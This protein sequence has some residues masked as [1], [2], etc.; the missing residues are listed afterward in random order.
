VRVDSLFPATV[1]AYGSHSS[2][3]Q[4]NRL[5]T[6]NKRTKFFSKS[7][8]PQSFRKTPI[9]IDEGRAWTSL[10]QFFLAIPGSGVPSSCGEEE[11]AIGAQQP[12][13]RWISSF[14]T[15]LGGDV[16]FLKSNVV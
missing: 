12:S 6:G 14:S 16:L 15:L 10:I 3:N 8:L 11:F 13:H 7:T 4:G 1:F 9:E 2:H 5:R